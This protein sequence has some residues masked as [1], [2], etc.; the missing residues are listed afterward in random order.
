MRKRKIEGVDFL[1]KFPKEIR[2]IIYN[3][4]AGTK[5]YWMDRF[6]LVL[7]SFWMVF[8]NIRP[9]TCMINRYDEICDYCFKLE[10]KCR[11]EARHF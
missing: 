10:N 5:G 6:D 3:Y 9:P 11:C 4:L 2:T 1:R 8:P 7:G